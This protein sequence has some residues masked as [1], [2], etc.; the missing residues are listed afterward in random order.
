MANFVLRPFQASLQYRGQYT[1]PAFDLFAN[2]IPVYRNLLKSLEKYGAHLQDLRYDAP[3]L[4]EANITCSLLDLSTDIRFRLDKWEVTFSALHEIGNEA[5]MQIGLDAWAA[6]QASDPSVK[7]IRHEM[8]FAFHADLVKGT[9]EDV[10]RQY[11]T[12][13]QALG[14]KTTSAIFFYLKGRGEGE[15]SGDILLYHSV[16]KEGALYLRFNV[17]YD[18]TKVP[19]ERLRERADEFV[20]TRLQQLGLEVEQAT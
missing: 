6:L 11:V 10:M 2:P 3:T 17:V 20:M 7:L 19:L 5:A 18:T 13:P 9:P 8:N 15:E 16:V 1:E 4:T 12:P 14:E